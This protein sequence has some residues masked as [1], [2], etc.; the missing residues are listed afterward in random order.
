MKVGLVEQVTP[1]YLTVSG[2]RAMLHVDRTQAT[3]DEDSTV[4]F[5]FGKFI[6]KTDNK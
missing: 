1:R 3:V 2:H 5:S 6:F 4:E